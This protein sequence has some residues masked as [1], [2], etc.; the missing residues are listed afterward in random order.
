MKSICYWTIQC[1]LIVLRFI[2]VVLLL[3]VW[4]IIKIGLYLQELTERDSL[5]SSRA[6]RGDDGE[7]REEEDDANEDGDT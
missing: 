5:P 2:M 7:R 3:P 4:L 6:K 1:V